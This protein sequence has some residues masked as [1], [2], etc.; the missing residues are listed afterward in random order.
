MTLSARQRRELV[1]LR[2]ENSC[3]ALEDADL[4]WRHQ[5]LRSAMN[6][7]YYSMFYAVSALA[8][9]EGESFRKHGQLI[10]FFQKK[11]VKSGIFAR[12][13][14]RALQKAFEDRSEADYQDYLHIKAEQVQARMTEARDFLTAV[15][16]FLS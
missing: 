3:Q 16:S 6:R 14:G 5:S 12:K 9:A 1:R 7:I 8:V 11:Y 10:A 4:L 15:R 2:L 13:Y